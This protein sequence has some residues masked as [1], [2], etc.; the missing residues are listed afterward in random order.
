M[1]Q[2]R[3]IHGRMLR[4]ISTHLSTWWYK[5]YGRLFDRVCH[6]LASESP[7]EAPISDYDELRHELKP[8]DVVLV[9]GRSRVARII[10]RLTLSRWSH[11]VLYIGRIDDI[12]GEKL[13]QTVSKHFDRSS[14]YKRNPQLIIESELGIGTVV[15]P[16]M[17]YQG[18]HLR[19]CR[20]EGLAPRD[21]DRV[22][23]FAASRLGQAYDIRQILDLCRMFM[24]AGILSR[25]RSVLY[26]RPAPAPRT[27]CAT[28][29]AEA[30][31][32][33]NFPVRPLVAYDKNKRRK[34]YQ[35]NP[36]YCT[37]GD[38]DYS[39][40]FQ[41]M[42]FP[43]PETSARGYYHKLP[44][45]QGRAENLAHAHLDGHTLEE[46]RKTREGQLH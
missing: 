7:L 12:E 21:R 31:S 11:A 44:W 40:W 36:L 38:F 45:Q 28:L 5:L 26:R 20:P 16:L 42:K 33:V 14:C 29:I 9:E 32:F 43:S 35:L 6:W 25:W 34:L 15:R 24:P 13:Q 46:L 8:G 17:V 37:P 19:I 30:F 10:Q 3:Q 2:G 41:V 22:L 1:V 4:A 23:A 27:T 18:E 39:P